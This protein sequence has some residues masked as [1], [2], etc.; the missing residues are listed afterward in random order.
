MPNLHVHRLVSLITIATLSLGLFVLSGGTIQAAQIATGTPSDTATPDS[1]ALPSGSPN[2][3]DTAVPQGTQEAQNDVWSP[4]V[5]LS[6][7]GAASA[8]VIA[9]EADGTLHALWWDKF[10][11]TKY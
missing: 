2:P 6:Q 9:A 3:A 11:G 10:D 8:P 4:P 5:N 7:S 1:S